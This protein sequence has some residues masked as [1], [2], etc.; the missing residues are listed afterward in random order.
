[1]QDPNSPYDPN[2]YSLISNSQYQNMM[3]SLNKY[4]GRPDRPAWESLL[5][6]DGLMQQPYQL[7]NS[8]NTGALDQMR[9]DLLR[10]PG[11][12]SQWRMLQ[13]QQLERDAARAASQAQG[14]VSQG[15]NQLAM[16][17]GLRSGAGE[18]MASQGAR[19]AS[20][21]RQG[22]LGNRLRLDIADEQQRMQGLG[23]LNQ[24]EMGAA[25]NAQGVDKYNIDK[26]LFD[27]MQKRYADMNAY[28]EE[29]RAWASEK[30]AQ[31]TPSGGGGKK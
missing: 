20:L 3:N 8:F 27:T 23:A 13:G 18:R 31:A 15:M 10:Q 4:A 6:S 24:A 2:Q 11:E 16:R 29:M 28:N 14:A 17:G 12:Q 25:Q 21:A 19:N 7:Q 22:V 26:A 5:G 9:S 30:T 1:M